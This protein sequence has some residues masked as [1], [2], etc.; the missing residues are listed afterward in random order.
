MPL[1]RIGVGASAMHFISKLVAALSS[2]S[3]GEEER[4]E[5]P[6][7]LVMECDEGTDRYS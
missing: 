7:F 3:N 4:T 1:A 5:Y 2:A 6:Y